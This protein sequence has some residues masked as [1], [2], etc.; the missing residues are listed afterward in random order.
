[1]KQT[2]HLPKAVTGDWPPGRNCKGAVPPW[3]GKFCILQ[4]EYSFRAFKSK[5][6][7]KYIIFGGHNGHKGA[8][9]LFIIENVFGGS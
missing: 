2:E 6:T 9:L 7:E 4:V 5:F 1:M 8:A 3:V